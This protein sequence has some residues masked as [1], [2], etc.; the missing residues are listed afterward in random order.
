[1]T[2]PGGTTAS[3]AAAGKPAGRPEIHIVDDDPA[4]RRAIARLLSLEDYEVFAYESAECFLA[5]Q[6]PARHGCLILDMALP[7]LDGVELQHALADRGNHLPIIF[8]AGDTDVPRTVHAMK[9]G[10]LDF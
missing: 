6:Q 1:M 7:G 9:Q 4:V 2:Q 5:G 10:A 3:F 8:L